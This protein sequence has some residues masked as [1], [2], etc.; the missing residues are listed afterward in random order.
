MSTGQI[1]GI[2]FLVAGVFDLILGFL[3]VGPRVPDEGRR[4]IVQITLTLGAVLLFAFGTA[5][6]TG[7]LGFGSAAIGE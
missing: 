4:R 5:F 6:L 3:V 7:A 1:V 2:A